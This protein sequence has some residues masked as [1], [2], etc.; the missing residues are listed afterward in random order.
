MK[1]KEP[2]LKIYSLAEYSKLQGKS[3]ETILR[4]ADEGL[5]RHIKSDEIGGHSYIVELLP[6][7]TKELIDRM[8]NIENSIQNI[9]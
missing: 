7:D 5:I 2:Y 6:T 3:K 8:E 1:A 9:Q 4:L